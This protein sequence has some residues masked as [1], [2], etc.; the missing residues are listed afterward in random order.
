VRLRWRR[1]ALTWLR[2]ELRQH[3]RQLSNGSPGR[4]DQARQ[5]LARWRNDSAFAGVRD[6]DGLAKLPPEE[7]QAWA[8]LWAEVDAALRSV[9]K[10]PL[11]KEP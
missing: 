4:G 1:Q 7:R 6:R 9:G 11:P 2:A 5:A 8:R 3:K 10:S